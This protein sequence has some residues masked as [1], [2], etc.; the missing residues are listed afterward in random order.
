MMGPLAS[1][2][3]PF[4]LALEPERLARLRGVASTDTV[5][6]LGSHDDLPWCEGIAYL[7]HDPEAPELL[8]PCAVAPSV[9]APLLLRAL[10]LRFSEKLRAPCAVWL[11]PPLVLSVANAQ[12]LDTSR[13]EQWRERAH[14]Q[15][16]GP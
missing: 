11:E 10:Q 1:L 4:L 12:T 15:R 13:L 7:A 14:V 6:V 2:A 16:S 8:V 5:L 9:P 3:R